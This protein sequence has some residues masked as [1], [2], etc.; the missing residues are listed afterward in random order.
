MTSIVT[1]TT[2]VQS[3]TEEAHIPVAQIPGSADLF[4]SV[5][6]VTHK[7]QN[8]IAL[9]V[10]DITSNFR[11]FAMFTIVDKQSMYPYVIFRYACDL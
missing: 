5:R 11:I 6:N 1:N 10:S 2:F 3:G 8:T 9:N 4:L 7:A